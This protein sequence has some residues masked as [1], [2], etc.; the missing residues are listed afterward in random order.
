MASVFLIGP[1]G[2]GKTTIAKELMNHLMDWEIINIDEEVEK[3]TPP[4]YFSSSNSL[5]LFF[6]AF[7]GVAVSLINELEKSSSRHLVFDVGAGCLQSKNS[8]HFFQSRNTV[9]IYDS[10]E[11]T[12]RKIQSRPG[13]CWLNN[14][15]VS[16]EA[17]EY[18]LSRH[19][20]YES[21]CYRIDV[22]K[23]S[24]K[25]AVNN[26]LSYLKMIQQKGLEP[27]YLMEPTDHCIMDPEFRTGK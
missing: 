23:C 22:G 24:L 13:N 7:F 20:L 16:F 10:P 11:N 9:L 4:I 5:E 27:F 26:L 21:S 15:V 6:E 1:S 2:V 18:S 19:M 3:I 8:L 17:V 12:L 14:T 25:E